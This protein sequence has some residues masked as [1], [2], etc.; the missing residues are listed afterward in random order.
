MSAMTAAGFRCAASDPFEEGAPFI[1]GARETSPYVNRLRLDWARMRED[2]LRHF[3]PPP[4]LP[5]TG[6]AYLKQVDGIYANDA[7]NS[8]SI[9]GYRVSAE[10]IE[11]VR[12]GRWNPESNRDDEAHRNALAARGYWQAFQ[13]VRR[14]LGRVLAGDNPGTVA[15]GDH[16]GWYRE[17][18]GP[19]VAVGLLAPADLAGYRSGPVYIR[20]SMHTPPNREAVRHLM[21]TLFELL[22]EEPSAA[23]R[24]VLGH[25]QFVYVHPYL[26]GN[27]RMGRFLMNVM[28]A[29]GGYPW[30]VVPLA[31]RETYMASLESASVDGDIVP[32][33]R[34]LGS[35]VKPTGTSGTRPK[36]PA[37]TRAKAKRRR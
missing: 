22:A 31:R 34:F 5:K 2:V 20:R 21:P 27:G 13:A 11:R 32:F 7:Y 19:S 14:S 37:K 17:L 8:L 1:F 6:A 35:L 36:A 28:A 23:V 16:A 10:L 25:F 12:S 9:E 3:P 24:V 4:G 33:T 26:D 30:I 15:D 18:F 29:S